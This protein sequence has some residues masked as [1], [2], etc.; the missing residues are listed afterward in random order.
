VL[1]AEPADPLGGAVLEMVAV[2]TREN[3]GREPPEHI[4][5]FAREAAG[6]GGN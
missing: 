3:L 4:C 6:A 5:R 2:L 1:T